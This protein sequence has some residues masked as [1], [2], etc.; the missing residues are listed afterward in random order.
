MG[1]FDLIF[2][3]NFVFFELITEDVA[4][5][6]QIKGLLTSGLIFSYP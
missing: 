6:H 1:N 4:I 2:G 5:F 3:A